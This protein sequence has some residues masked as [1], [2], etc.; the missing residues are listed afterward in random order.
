MKLLKYSGHSKVIFL[1]IGAGLALA[2]CLTLV[3]A[4]RIRDASRQVRPRSISP[5]S[6]EI[7]LGAG[8]NLQEAIKLAKFGDT[9]ILEAGATYLGPVILPN[10]G[11]G[12]GTDA[13]YITIRTANLSEIAKD[14][15]RIK[16][17]VH[18][19]FMPKI[20]S[21]S[22]SV[23][24]GTEPQAHH[25]R[26]VG[27]EFAPSAS[28]N[29]VFNLI[30]LGASDYSSYSSFPHHLVFDRCYV[31]STGLNKARRGFALNSGEASIIN[32]HISGFAGAGDETQAISSWNGPGPFHII[33]NFL[34]AGSELILIGGSDPSIPNL[35]PSDI[36]IRRNYFHRPS[37]W[38]GKA[39]IKG[40]FELK[41]ARRVVVD[42][43]CL[44]AKS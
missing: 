13:D 18:S 38:S 44:K 24:V 17:A 9:I 26:F 32:S 39:T 20:V 41:N 12:S 10:K 21:P 1:L 19:R 30:D 22:Q 7:V 14:G 25:Y 2:F 11:P 5:N 34:E 4:Q 28:A 37:E 23:A 43:I 8:G 16:P 36:E 33:N 40:T 35:V 3:L 27:V 6:R 42:A 15:E 31:H 29:Y